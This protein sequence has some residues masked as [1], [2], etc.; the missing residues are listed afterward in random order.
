M[1]LIRIALRRPITVI[2]LVVAL[3]LSSVLAIHA[4]A[5]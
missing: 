2:V 5:R 4:D 1:W 3:A